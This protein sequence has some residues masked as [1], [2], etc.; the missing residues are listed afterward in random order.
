VTFAKGPAECKLDP[1][2]PTRMSLMEVYWA[3][4]RF[5]EEHRRWATSA[6]E[7]GLDLGGLRIE[8]SDDSYVAILGNLAI[9]QD[10][11]ILQARDG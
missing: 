4:R 7:L 3:Q 6:F 10:S 9:R 8:I 5:Y 2:H 11:K 1:D